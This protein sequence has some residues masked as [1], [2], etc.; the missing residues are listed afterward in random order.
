MPGAVRAFS[1]KA[2]LKICSRYHEL[3]KELMR[4]IRHIVEKNLTPSLKALTSKAEQWCRKLI[5]P[6]RNIKD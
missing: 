5:T 4:V 3:A 1:I 6:Q 2:M